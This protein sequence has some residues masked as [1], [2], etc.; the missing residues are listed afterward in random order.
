MGVDNEIEG[1]RIVLG[2]KEEWGVWMVCR[3][4]VDILKRVGYCIVKVNILVFF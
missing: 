3:V 4:V 1:V 2:S